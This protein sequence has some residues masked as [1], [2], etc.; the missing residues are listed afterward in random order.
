MYVYM[1]EKRE[2]LRTKA[3]TQ[4]Q[5]KLLISATRKTIWREESRGDGV[6]QQEDGSWQI[7]NDRCSSESD[8]FDVIATVVGPI[9][10]AF[11]F[12]ACYWQPSCGC[13]RVQWAEMEKRLLL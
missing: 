1:I 8:D 3:P 12:Y 4:H 10:S 7:W 9:S 11:F 13:C 5:S 2:E 6:K